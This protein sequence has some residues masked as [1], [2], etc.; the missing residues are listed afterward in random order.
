[1]FEAFTKDGREAG[2]AGEGSGS[3]EPGGAGERR[4]ADAG[5][6][7]RRHDD[8]SGLGDDRGLPPDPA[9]LVA[10]IDAANAAVACAQRELLHLIGEAKQLDDLWRDDG[11]R[12]LAHWLSI[13][14]GVSAWKASRWIAAAEALPGLP[15]TDRALAAGELGLDKAVELTRFAAPETE[16]MLLRWAQEVSVATVRRRAERAR[17]PD[18]EEIAGDERARRLEW[19]WTED[20]RR[21]GIAG[22]LP[23]AA[24]AV[25]V[26]ALERTLERVPAL[27]GEEGPVGIE[28]RRADALVAVCSA[29]LAGDPDA[30]RATVVLHASLDRAGQLDQAELEGATAVARPVAERLACDARLEV[31]LEDASGEAVALGRARR[32]PSAAMIRQ[33][34]YRD[35]GCRFPGCGTNAFTQA[36]HVVWWSK[37]GRT[38]LRNLV[39]VCTFHHRLVHEHGWVIHRTAAGEL[40]WTPPTAS[41]TGP[42]RGRRRSH[43]RPGDRPLEG[44]DAGSCVAS[45]GT[46]RPTATDGV[47]EACRMSAR[48]R[49]VRSGQSPLCPQPAVG[50]SPCPANSSDRTSPRPRR[51]S[52]PDAPSRRAP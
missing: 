44:R 13:R 5:V 46:G 29:S 28:A 42:G 51:S 45:S 32:D 34:R 33:L 9:R 26:R 1:M 50:G 11:A 22:E 31:V 20:A 12:D 17:R 25:V 7:T 14:Y 48:F 2:E 47:E 16:A 41:A 21:L 39:L 6:A 15:A 23:A 38:E 8:G 36:H 43:E 10:A 49:R 27:P 19:W 4:P 40:R 37:G 52:G 30:D 35:R 24:G 18:R 3:G